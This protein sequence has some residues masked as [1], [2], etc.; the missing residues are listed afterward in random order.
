MIQVFNAHKVYGSSSP[1]LDN[2]SLNVK[3]GEFV[4]LT[5]PSG[6][7]KT[8]LL[9]ILFRWENIDSGQIL[10]NGVNISKIPANK[11]YAHRRQIGFVFQDYRLLP[12]KTVFENIAFAQ[13]ILGIPQK[14]VRKRTWETLKNVGLTHKKDSFPLQLSGGE[15][16]RAAIARALVNDPQ[17][18]LADEPTGNLDP[19]I[20]VEILKLFEKAQSLGVTIVFATHNQEMIR[21]GKHPVIMLH[22]G[23][24][25]QP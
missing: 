17:L 8:T 12:N 16:Q 6:A 24:R 10:I 25:V 14:T 1:A 20:S 2:V 9:K 13:E 7:G 22:R 4:F 3:R 5:G 11:I 15:Q 18:I 21:S 19:E 23:K